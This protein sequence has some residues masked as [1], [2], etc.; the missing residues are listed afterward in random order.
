VP[1]VYEYINK[2]IQHGRVEMTLI[3]HDTD[4]VYPP[5]RS[6][7]NFCL[8]APESAYEEEA[9]KEIAATIQLY[10]ANEEGEE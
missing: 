7:K 3:A 2:L 5:I 1:Y 4:S 6:E 10:D 9:Q 8:T